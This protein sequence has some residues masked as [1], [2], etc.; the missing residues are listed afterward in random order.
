MYPNTYDSN[1]SDKVYFPNFNR[2]TPPS[3]V[4]TRTGSL[5]A[6]FLDWKNMAVLYDRN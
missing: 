5:G 4:P 1:F 6:Q 2:L 3:W